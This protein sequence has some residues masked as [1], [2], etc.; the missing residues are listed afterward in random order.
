MTA[1]LDELLGTDSPL[2]AVHQPIVDLDTR[3]VVAYEALLRGPEGPLESPV[4]LFAAARREG[5]L[6]ELDWTA[7]TVAARGIAG[8]DVGA[9]SLFIN[10]EPAVA[11]T[12]PP[13]HLREAFEQDH[14]GLAVCVEL[15]ERALASDPAGLIRAADRI[16]GRGW[17][18]A[19]DDV[20]AEPSSLA[21][22]PLLRPDVIKL[23]MRLIQA[24]ADDQI[25]RII[26]ATASEAQRTGA[27]L[28]AEGIETQ[29][30]EDRALAWGATLG[31]GHLYGRPER[32][33]HFESAHDW[34]LPRLSPAS[35]TPSSPVECLE[36][37]VRWRTGAKR[38]LLPLSCL[39]ERHALD[40]ADPCVVLTCFQHADY[41][42]TAAAR[43]YHR[44]GAK[45][46]FVA[47]MGV[48]LSDNPAG[49][50]GAHLA[51]DDP[52]VHEWDVIVIGPHFAG[53][54]VA[55]DLGDGGPDLERRFRYAVTYDRGEVADA[56]RQMM[57]R[58]SPLPDV[59]D[60]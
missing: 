47:V 23:D 60:R 21:L 34:D 39:L 9:V 10:I 52:L 24:R 12:P 7:R 19:L 13:E 32:Q 41:F 20:G 50:R 49:L 46:A 17:R 2:Y 3:R 6:A 8:N 33:P 51:P 36:G 57:H 4:E 16:R 37:R 48:G 40:S 55:H 58:I 53:A 35:A 42:S 1:T 15:T 56:A 29:E 27:A 59:L 18:L 43:R 30:H 14:P 26:A 25:A 38:M 11:N 44:L 28:L 54:L 31:Q 5:R 22:L 45:S